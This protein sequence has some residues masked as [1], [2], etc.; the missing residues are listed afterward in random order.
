MPAHIYLVGVCTITEVWMNAC[1]GGFSKKNGFLKD[2]SSLYMMDTLVQAA[3]LEAMVGTLN[4]GFF[5]ISPSAL[6]VSVAFPPPMA[7][8]MS[9]SFTL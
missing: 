2:P 1:T 9:A 3:Q 6:A 5:A 8:I 7:K 4:T